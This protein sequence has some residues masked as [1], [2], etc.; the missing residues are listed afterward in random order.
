M[1]G[2]EKTMAE[3]HGMLKTTEDSLK[4]NSNHV[5]I[6]QKEKKKRKCW[7]P[8]EGK[9]KEKVSDDPSSSMPKTKGKFGA[10]PD[11][12]RFHCHKKGYWFRNYK[13]YFE[14]QK[15]KNTSE[16]S[17]LGINVTEINIAVSSSDSCVFDTGLM[18]QTCKSLQ[19]LSLTRIF[20][21]GKLDV[22]VGNGAKAAAITVGT[23]HLPLHSRLV[24]QLNNCYCVPAL[25]KNNISSLCL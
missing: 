24:L 1:N 5:M 19:G 12:E 20:A 10:S 7:M 11:E 17:S 18:I 21:K 16:T 8:P 9:G 23:F 15:K 13:K 4:K 22:C 25:S 14:E 6:V 2:M 3:L